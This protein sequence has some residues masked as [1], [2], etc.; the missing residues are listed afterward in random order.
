[1]RLMLP[2]LRVV[3]IILE[4]L[5]SPQIRLSANLPP[6]PIHSLPQT[7]EKPLHLSSYTSPIVCQNKPCT[8][9]Y[10]LSV[11]SRQPRKWKTFRLH[12]RSQSPVFLFYLQLC[13]TAVSWVSPAICTRARLWG[14]IL[15]TKLEGA[16]LLIA[17]PNL[18]QRCYCSQG[19]F[20]LAV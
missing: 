17:Q 6:C 8:H 2:G 9:F 1:M 13:L 19:I 16:W 4:C 7:S 5:W 10:L 15:P 20:C 11:A 14:R 12:G 3:A 18:H